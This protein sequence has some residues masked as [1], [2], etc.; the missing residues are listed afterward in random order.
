M[1]H[2]GGPFHTAVAVD[3]VDRFFEWFN[4]ERPNMALGTSIRETPAQ[5][6]RRK[7]PKPG[8]TSERPRGV[9]RL[10]RTAE[11]RYFL[12]MTVYLVPPHPRTIFLAMILLGG[13]AFTTTA[14]FF[15][16][17]TFSVICH[18]QAV[19]VQATKHAADALDHAC[20]PHRINL[21]DRLDLL[22]KKVGE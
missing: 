22:I 19:L 5:A 15:P 7:M 14:S 11:G 16:T 9:G 20:N 8:D 2:A 17:L 6:C 21:V 10:R 1:A 4:N 3:P 12:Y 18:I 13:M